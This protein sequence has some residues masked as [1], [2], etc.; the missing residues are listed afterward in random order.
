MIRLKLLTATVALV[1]SCGAG[2]E[3]PGLSFQEIH[4]LLRT[5]LV[6]ADEGQLD[7]AAAAGLLKAV[8]PRALLLTNGAAAT[9]EGPALA[10]STVYDGPSGYLRLAR[11]GPG[12]AAEIDSTMSALASTNTSKIKGWILDLRNADGP[13]YESAAAVADRFLATEQPL[14]DFGQGMI[15]SKVKNNPIKGPLVVLVNH[16]TGRAAEA[17][18]AVLRKAELALLL[19]TNTAGQA[20]VTKDFPLRNGQRLRIATALV[21]TGDGEPLPPQGL[22]PD[23]L[24]SVSPEDERLYLE[25]PYRAPGRPG[26][27][28]A[29]AGLDL[30]GSA[31]ATN[32][33]HRINEADL[34]RML[35]AGEDF[36]EEGDLTRPSEPTGP[37]L[38]DPALVRALDLLK[39]LAVV[40]RLK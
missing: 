23:I 25:D 34:V 24:I 9:A 6:N 35:K 33:R 19:G 4:D 1:V 20:F 8:A 12:L 11:L 28:V 21:R 38:R 14:L 27:S 17:L 30:N 3:T 40:K 36:D 5:N 16:R 13:D 10:R 31:S 39:G 15:K 32:T 26:W 37:V 29:R 22:K 2:A 18:A 7:R